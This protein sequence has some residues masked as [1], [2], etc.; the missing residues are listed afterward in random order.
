MTALVAKPLRVATAGAVLALSIFSI[1]PKPA[2]A[3]YPVIDQITDC[4]VGIA[5]YCSYNQDG[6]GG[7]YVAKYRVYYRC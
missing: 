1:A 3:C 7:V 2:E 4:Y 6:T 5:T